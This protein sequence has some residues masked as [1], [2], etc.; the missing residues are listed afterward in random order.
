MIYEEDAE[1]WALYLQ[2]VFLR[3]L[4]RE[5]VRLCC[6]GPDLP[7]L[8]SVRCKLL[9]LSDGL[10]QG[11]TPEKSHFL[12]G[13]LAPPESVVTLLCG[14]SSSEPLYQALGVPRGCWELT[15]EQEPEDYVCAVERLLLRGKAL[16]L[17]LPW[18]VSLGPCPG[19]SLRRKLGRQRR[20]LSHHTANPGASV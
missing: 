8:P 12:G 10:L 1:E 15:T 20:P 18:L 16:P 19:L 14:P 11:L 17:L 6:L 9:I 13:A 7:H 4:E 2:E 3:V 5:S